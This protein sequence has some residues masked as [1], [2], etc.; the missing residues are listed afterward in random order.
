MWDERYA[1]DDYLFGTQPARFLK[2][3]EHLLSPGHHALSIADGEGRNAVFMAERGLHV[4]A[5]DASQNA[6]DKARRL[7]DARGVELDLHHADIETWDWQDNTYDV[8]VGVFFQFAPP[9]Q[10]A[11]IFDGIKA[12]LKPGG[13]ALVHGYRPEQVDYATGGPA[14]REHMYTEQL[15]RQAFHDFDIQHLRA[16]DEHIEEGTAHSG[17]SALIDLIA[18]KPHALKTPDEAQP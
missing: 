3:H 15:L 11:A 5:F 17:M 14:Q 2:R 8:I 13:L 16:Y 1:T 7:A 6:L 10:R 18:R 9:G 12:A 4:S